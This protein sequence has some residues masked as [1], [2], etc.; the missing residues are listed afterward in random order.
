LRPTV[1]KKKYRRHHPK[2]MMRQ[3]FCVRMVPAAFAHPLT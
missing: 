3:F 1:T 2:K